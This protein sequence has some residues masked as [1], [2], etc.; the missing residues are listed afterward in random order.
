L[1]LE[2]LFLRRLKCGWR[3]VANTTWEKKVE[4][5]RGGYV[6]PKRSLDIQRKSRIRTE[7]VALPFCSAGR[8][9]GF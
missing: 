3:L 8:T 4:M 9:E 2:K 6:A 1:N 7:S 5:G